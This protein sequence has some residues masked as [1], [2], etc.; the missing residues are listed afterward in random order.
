LGHNFFAFLN[1]FGSDEGLEAL[2]ASTHTLLEDKSWTLD[3]YAP[4]LSTDDIFALRFVLND[5]AHQH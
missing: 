3:N 4:F 1:G 2:G 5:W